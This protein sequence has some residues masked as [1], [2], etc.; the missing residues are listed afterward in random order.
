MT[1]GWGGVWTSLKH[2][3]SI[4]NALDPNKLL[5]PFILDAYQLKI[6]G[7]ELDIVDGKGKVKV[8]LKSISGKTL[9]VKVFNLSGGEETLVFSVTPQVRIK[10]LNWLVDGK[11]F[12][13]VDEIRFKIVS[14]EYTLPEALFLLPDF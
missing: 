14:P 3:M 1:N 5:G 10:S 7:I 11:G 12:A 6:S 2:N 13:V 9:Y 4:R 8:E